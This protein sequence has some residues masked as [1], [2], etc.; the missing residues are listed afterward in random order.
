M[1]INDK[2]VEATVQDDDLE[3]AILFSEIR[4][5]LRTLQNVTSLKILVL[6]IAKSASENKGLIPPHEILKTLKGALLALND[7][8]KKEKELEKKS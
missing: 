4:D 2:R 6:G 1:K 3:K 7:F 5:S 8:E